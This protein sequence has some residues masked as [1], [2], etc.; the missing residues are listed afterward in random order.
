MGW[1]EKAFQEVNISDALAEL[2]KMIEGMA[3]KLE[4][5]N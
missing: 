2:E 1:K 3:E 5:G 4:Q